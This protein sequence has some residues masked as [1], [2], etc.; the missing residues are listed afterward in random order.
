MA[1]E[2][3]WS[4]EAKEDYRATVNYLLDHYSDEVAERYT[5]KLFDA[6]ETLAQMPHI[7]RKHSELSAIRQQIVRPYTVVFYMVLPTQ[8]IVVNLR[9]SRQ[10]K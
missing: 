1:L 3:V 5:D 7:G 4:L 10:I 6:L 9:D 8:L 2:I